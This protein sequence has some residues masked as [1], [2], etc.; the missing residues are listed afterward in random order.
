MLVTLVV[1]AKSMLVMMF[2]LEK[3]CHIIAYSYRVL[4][5]NRK[6]DVLA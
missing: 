2:Q 3:L 4:M 5:H 6:S 1:D